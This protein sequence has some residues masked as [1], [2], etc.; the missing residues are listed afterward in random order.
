MQSTAEIDA[1]LQETREHVSRI[2]A[3]DVVLG[4]PT[5]NNRATAAAVS[6]AG[7]QGLA[8][9]LSQV[10]AVII[11]ADG[12]SKDGTPEHLR[13]VVGDRLPLIQVRYPLY[14]VHKLSAPLAGVPGGREA[15]AAVFL[16]SRQLGA[17]VCAVLDSDVQ[18]VSPEW[19]SRL[20]APVLDHDIDLVIP[21][22]LRHKFDGMINSGIVH[23]FVRALYGKRVRQSIGADAAFSA[24]LID[25]YASRDGMPGPEPSSTDPRSGVSAICNGFQVGQT[26]LGPRVLEARE[27][28]ADLSA[29]LRQVLTPLFEQMES[30]AA[31]WQKVR[32]SDPVPWFGPSLEVNTEPAQ[33]NARRMID[34]FRLGCQDLQ[35]VWSRVLPP[36]TLLELRKLSRQSE[37][38]FRFPDEVWARTVYDFALGFH[39]RVIGRDHLLA[40]ITPLYLG[41]VASFVAEI[42]SAGLDEVE[43]RLER[44]STHFE[45]QKRY[46][47]SRWRWPDRFNP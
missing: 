20:T 15:L 3:A 12:G 47:I 43:E 25:F 37:D 44:L 5:Y 4:I 23:P 7:A 42:D 10:R 22:Y 41:W 35:E 36:A 19:V 33:V 38:A 8:A 31:F 32:G 24:R 39:M 34:S 45:T 14:P 28:S 29:T 13:E 40:A 30:T 11:N 17:K 2:G 46:L 6:E 18:S 16:L 21:A 27:V 9:Q 1:I 26:F